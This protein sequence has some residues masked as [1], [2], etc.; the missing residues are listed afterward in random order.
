MEFMNYLVI[1]RLFGFIVG[2]MLFYY[3]FRLFNALKSKEIA[4]SMVF[5][6]KDRIINLF[7]LLVLASLLTFIVGIFFVMDVSPLVVE[8]ILDLN[9]LALLIF[10]FL[11]QKLMGGDK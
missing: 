5:L 11:L 9:A 6:H 2:L 8:P 7:G 4:L 10:T 1:I 3:A